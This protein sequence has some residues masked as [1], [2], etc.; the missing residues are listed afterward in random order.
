MSIPN[1]TAV[2]L[3]RNVGLADLHLNRQV[4]RM[5]L[6]GIQHTLAAHGSL[7]LQNLKSQYL[8]PWHPLSLRDHAVE[9][10]GLH[11]SL[12]VAAQLLWRER[13][14]KTTCSARA[15]AGN[16]PACGPYCSACSLLIT[17]SKPCQLSCRLCLLHLDAKTFQG[18]WKHGLCCKQRLQLHPFKLT[19]VFSLKCLDRPADVANSVFMVEGPCTTYSNVMA[20]LRTGS[21]A[22][23]REIAQVLEGQLSDGV[24]FCH[25]AELVLPSPHDIERCLKM[26]QMAARHEL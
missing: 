23:L 18:G 10:A 22:G 9:Q 4:L 12:I 16:K 17:K 7:K 8:S 15:I 11:Q 1:F 13:C 20:N 3:G 21:G 6:F 14:H 2:Q 26:Y 24:Q 19:V 25:S 5:W